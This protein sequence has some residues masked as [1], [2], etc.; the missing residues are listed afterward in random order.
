MG[1]PSWLPGEAGQWK[2]R[3]PPC[4]SPLMTTDLLCDNK[5]YHG[6]RVRP[7]RLR[8]PP[9]LVHRR[10][11]LGPETLHQAS[12]HVKPACEVDDQWHIIVRGSVQQHDVA[13]FAVTDDGGHFPVAG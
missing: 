8:D 12:L 7:R 4:Q 9:Q 2:A 1:P 5:F 10:K 6:S 3:N 11:G 13:T